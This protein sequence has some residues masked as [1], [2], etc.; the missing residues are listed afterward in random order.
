MNA[1]DPLAAPVSYWQRGCDD[2]KAGRGP[3]RPF[4]NV[5]S[6]FG[7]PDYLERLANEGYM[8]GHRF[9]AS[10]RHQPTEDEGSLP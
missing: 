2:A 6:T 3:R 9:G 8:N 10:R 7:R 1:L 4:P 5:T